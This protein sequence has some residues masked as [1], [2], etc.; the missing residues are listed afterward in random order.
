MA[1]EPTDGAELRELR[2]EAREL[3]DGWPGLNGN[4]GYAHDPHD[5]ARNRAARE[6]KALE[7]LRRLASLPA[8]PGGAR[9]PW[10]C[11]DCDC[12]SFARIDEPQ[13]GGGFAP[14]P[15]IRCVNCK[16]EYQ[17]PAAPGGEVEREPVLPHDLLIG[18]VVLRKGVS[19]ATAQGTANR[20]AA[21]VSA[22]ETALA[23]ERARAERAEAERDEAREGWHL[24]NGAADLAM[25]H[26]DVAETALTAARQRN[27]RLVEALGMAERAL[28][29]FANAINSAEMQHP[30]PGFATVTDRLEA[31][32]QGV[33]LYEFGEARFAL[34]QARAA[35]ASDSSGDGG[36]AC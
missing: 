12:R 6:K 25:K 3:L 19:I 4:Y 34:N 33:T 26:R 29:S 35:R 14:G 28:T 16:R 30:Y 10:R 7:I 27:D 2:R 8:A 11:P 32:R 31:A 21:R 24:A 18:H 13:Q 23:Q 1:K 20:L 17:H 5:E 36:E 22:L 15:M 9:E